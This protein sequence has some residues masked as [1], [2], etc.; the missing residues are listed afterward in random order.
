LGGARDRL[1]YDRLLAGPEAAEHM[2]DG[3]SRFWL[4]HPDAQARILFRAQME[5][6]VPQ[7]IVSPVATAGTQPQFAQRQMNVVTNDEQVLEGEL[8][9]IQESTHRTAAQVH[10]CLGL[11]EQEGVI[12]PFAF[13]DEGL[14]FFSKGANL[15]MAGQVVDDLE[16]D[17]VARADVTIAGVAQTDDDFHGSIRSLAGKSAGEE[18]D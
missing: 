5:L 9:K 14:K 1:G 4:P 11:D 13:R 12:T 17:V 8:V 10:V 18:A 3:L 16:A 15:E 2:I 6:D 7:A